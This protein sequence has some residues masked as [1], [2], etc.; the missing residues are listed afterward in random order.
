M[1]STSESPVDVPAMPK[2]RPSSAE[3]C[4]RSFRTKCDCKLEDTTYQQ[5]A[6]VP[7][8]GGADV[9]GN[10]FQK[11][12][13]SDAD[14]HKVLPNHGHTKSTRRVQDRRARRFNSHKPHAHPLTF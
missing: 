13:T 8:H 12:G 6:A 7:F 9:A 5:K 14:S 10:I 1:P 2:H 3:I 4:S 11:A